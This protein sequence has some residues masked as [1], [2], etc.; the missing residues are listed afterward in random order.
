MIN[1]AKQKFF[2]AFNNNTDTGIL[3]LRFVSGILMLFN[4]GGSKIMAGTDRWDK[5][6]HALTDIIGLEILS[7][8]FGFMASFAESIGALLIVFGLYTRMSSFLLFFTMVIASLKH[9]IEGEF[10]ELAFIYGLVSLVLMISGAGRFSVDYYFMKKNEE[11][12]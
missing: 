10:S 5:L 12:N 2:L 11:N 8:F 1:D 9:V 7:V 4:H 6:G 3:V